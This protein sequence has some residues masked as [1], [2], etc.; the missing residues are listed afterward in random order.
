MLLVV[1]VVETKTF[2]VAAVSCGGG[3]DS[4][5]LILAGARVN[6]CTEHKDMTARAQ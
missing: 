6:A 1:S 4:D 3:V 2:V 5:E